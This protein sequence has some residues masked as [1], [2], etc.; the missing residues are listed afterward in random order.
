[1]PDPKNNVAPIEALTGSLRDYREPH[2]SD[3]LGRVD[4][5]FRWQDLRRQ[6]QLWPYSRATEQ[7]P[8]TFCTAR[9]DAGSPFAG[10]NFG[11]QDYLSLGSH[12]GIKDAAKEAIDEYGVHSA[13]SPAFLGSTRYSLALERTIAD[14]LGMQ[15]TVLFP[16]GWAAGFGVIRGLVRPSDHVVIDAL[17]HSCLQEGAAAATRNVHSHRHLDVDSARRQLT[18]IRAHDT[19]NAILV[20]TESLFSMDSDTPDIAALQDLCREFQAT[21]VVDAAHD[22]GNLGDDGRGHL[23]LQQ[24]LGRVDI[25]MGSFSKTFASNGGFV[26]CNSPAVREYLKFYCSP[27]MFSNALAPAQAATVLK[28]FDIVTSSE[29]RA[30][31]NQLMA[32]IRCLRTALDHAGFEV[33]GEP[34]AIVPVL[35][36]AEGLARLVA[37]RLPTLGLVANLVEYPAV[38]K[39]SARFRFQVMAKHSRKN[40]DDAVDRLRTAYHESQIAFRAF[41]SLGGAAAGAVASAGD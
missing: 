35:M 27:Q 29:G 1:M 18:R 26:T 24:M 22:L 34:S 12:P 37:R 11:S 15:H 7:A 40:I 4:R 39:G 2:G 41:Q 13:G 6:H 14:F 38:A 5:F 3:L 30:L 8:G 25:V 19:E 33:L 9:D 17:A 20:V 23:G 36:H 32:N 16:T 10:V 31:R 28:A 21:L